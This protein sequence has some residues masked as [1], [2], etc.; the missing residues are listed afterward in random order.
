MDSCYTLDVSLRI[1]EICLKSAFSAIGQIDQAD[2]RYTCNPSYFHTGKKRFM[3]INYFDRVVKLTLYRY[4]V[5]NPLCYYC[6]IIM[7]TSL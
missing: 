7:L 2:G 3:H 5:V 4:D 6:D 1:S